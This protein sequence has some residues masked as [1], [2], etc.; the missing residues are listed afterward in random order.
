MSGLVGYRNEE[1]SIVVKDA[2]RR[3]RR[4]V[5]LAAADGPGKGD[6]EPAGDEA[7]GRDEERDHAH[8]GNARRPNQRV[9]PA[10]RPM[11]VSEL[12]GISTAVASGVSRPVSASPSPI[13]L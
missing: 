1:R 13:A 10:L 8:G 11:M 3:R 5:E 6:E 7:A 9:A 2:E 12:T 4:V